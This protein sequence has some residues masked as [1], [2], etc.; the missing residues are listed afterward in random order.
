MPTEIKSMV[1]DEEV[2]ALYEQ[3]REYFFQ[4][5]VYEK[6]DDVIELCARKHLEEIKP[7]QA[8]LKIA[9]EALEKIVPKADE[10]DT[11]GHMEIAYNSLAAIKASGTD[12]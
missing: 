6:V 9:V 11:C 10:F 8:Q 2:Q 4:I 12:H 3:W 1:T 5:G 7:L